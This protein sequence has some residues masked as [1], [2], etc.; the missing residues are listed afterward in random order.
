MPL[1]H[2]PALLSAWL[3]QIADALDRRSAPRLLALLVGAL[4]ARGRR[5]V[6]SWFRAAGVTTDFRRAYSAL[7]PGHAVRVTGVPRGTAC[8]RPRPL[9]PRRD[10]PGES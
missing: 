7:L 10:S 6:T 1:S 4:L 8:G 5:T 2:L 3:S 9:L